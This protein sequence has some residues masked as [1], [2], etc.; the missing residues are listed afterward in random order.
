MKQP[1]MVGRAI[2]AIVLMVGFYVL[3]LSI[4]AG[5]LWLIY[6]QVALLGRVSLK[7]SFLFLLLAGTI[8]SSILPR[9]DRFTP[10]GPRLDPDDNPELFAALRDVAELTRQRSFTSHSNG[11]GRCS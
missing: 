8:L 3:A 5:R 9:P 7:L 4:A 6:A 2:S 1:S 10:P 11:M